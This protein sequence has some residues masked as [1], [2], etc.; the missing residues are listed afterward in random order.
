MRRS[1]GPVR[2]TFGSVHSMRIGSWQVAGPRLTGP[3][4]G[5]YERHASS[6]R[7][8]PTPIGCRSAGDQVL[9]GEVYHRDY[10]G[11][12]LSRPCSVQ[13]S[14]DVIDVYASGSSVSAKLVVTC[15]HVA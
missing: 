15:R 6:W 1:R 8:A 3:V 11:L 12:D 14:F 13:T 5:L 10:L 9:V 2:D 4:R 7:T